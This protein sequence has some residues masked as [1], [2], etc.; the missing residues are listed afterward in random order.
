MRA[1]SLLAV[2]FVAKTLTFMKW[3]IPISP[4]TPIGA[5]WQD[6]LVALIF[7][8]V[9]RL[10]R[11]DRAGWVL[12]RIGVFYIALNVPVALVLSSPLTP[13]MMRAARGPLRDSI[14]HYLNVTNVGSVV[15]IVAAGIILPLVFGRLN[16][17]VRFP[18]L[19]AACLIV[20]AGPYAG[21]KVDM[22]GLHR[23]AFGALWPAHLSIAAS[24]EADSL[25]WRTSPFSTEASESLLEYRGAASGRNVVLVM[26]ESTG[27]QYLRPYV[28]ADDPMPRLTDLASHSIV[29]DN[30]YSVYP[31]SIKGL[32][33][34]LCSNDPSFNT[35]AE[36]VATFPCSS[37]AAAFAGAGYRTGL[38]HSGRFAYLGMQSVV[39]GR[40]FDTLEDAAAIGGDVHSS[41]GVDDRSTVRRILSWI[42]STPPGQRFFLTYL[43]VAGHHPYA[44]PE[45][46]P[47]EGDNEITDYFNALHYS[48]ASLSELI[49]GIRE[50]QLDRNTIF[51]IAGDHGEAFGR[52]EGNFGHTLFIYDEN[53]HVPFI[54]AAPGLIERQI[55]VKRVASLIDTAPTLLDLT[56][57]RIPERVAGRSL[58]DPSAMMALFFTDYSLPL[59]GLR[60]SCWKY[61]FEMD[62]SRSKLFDVCKEPGESHNLAETEAARV[63]AYRNR[64]T[65]WI[66][67]RSPSLRSGF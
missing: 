53:V 26:L 63:S 7:A 8:A 23:N 18:V 49:V 35:S 41:F 37:L 27:A 64:L 42:D 52:H 6:V 40:G 39:D 65:G 55:R 4:W 1:V 38:F 21:G 58:L 67:S 24:A 59:A 19:C 33:A 50:R 25:D 3:G 28:A 30:A 45:R 43:P 34:T 9:D 16:F 22:R 36:T 10:I 11:N 47:F 20:M 17:H 62:S 57:I 31:E 48:D 66:S 14:T 56:G 51:V 5:F 2:L 44:V 15:L 12:Y 13:A 46:G 32:F 60:D 54:V 29:F 61:I